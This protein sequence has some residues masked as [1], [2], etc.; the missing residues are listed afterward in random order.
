MPQRSILVADDIESQDAGGK[1][2]SKAIRIVASS[3]AQQLKASIDLL[4]VEDIKTYFRDRFDVSRL[5][6]W[7]S[8]HQNKLEK[9]GGQ[10]TVPVH[11]F[12]EKG[13]PP[14]QI[15]KTL[16]AKT[17]PELVVMGTQGLTGMGRMLIGSVAE[18]V[19]RNSRRPVMVI[20]PVAQK[21]VQ[22]FGKQK[23]IDILVATDLGKNS[24]TAELYALSLAKRIGARVF[25]FH[26]LGDSYRAI[27][28]DSGTVSGWVPLNLDQVLSQIRDD[29]VK[30]LE[31]KVRFFQSRGVACDY[32]IN[33]KVV[34]ASCAV[35]QEADFGYSFI[36]MGTHGRNMLLEAYLGSVAR[37]T[38]LNSS[39]PVITVHS[40]R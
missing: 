17:A 37:E 3:L 16:Q 15:L 18:E 2:R 26:C 29:S 22:D 30:S 9:I 33:E 28:R 8:H 31:Q 20:G 7:S 21:K 11:T 19:I 25:M 1:N 5:P 13:S 38:I 35:Y 32:R 10:F 12:L 14:E 36:I 34:V 39:I 4:Y 6:S 23:Q 40:G 24:R 27:I